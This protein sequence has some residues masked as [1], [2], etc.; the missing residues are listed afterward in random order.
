[1]KKCGSTLV[2]TANGLEI[3][4]GVAQPHDD[5]G[6]A[7][8]AA[9]EPLVQAAEAEPAP[10]RSR[11]HVGQ[12]AGAAFGQFWER[13][14][15]DLPTWLLGIGIF[16]VMICLFWPLLDQDKVARRKAAHDAAERKHKQAQK[17]Y[18]RRIEE[19]KEEEAKG[20]LREAKNDAQK[21]W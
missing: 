13:I 14:K 8:A 1:C 11:S 2:V 5:F 10:L 17:D 21:K 15:G 20:K 9:V 3:A 7:T 19:A 6:G 4:G 16:L 18:D 12:G